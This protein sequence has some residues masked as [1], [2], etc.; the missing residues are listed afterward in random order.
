M[1]I[2]I[3]M[4]LCMEIYKWLFSGE[5]RDTGVMRFAHSVRSGLIFVRMLRD[6]TAQEDMGIY[7]IK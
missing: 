3:K 5:A 4:Y 2:I 6:G 7:N 1:F